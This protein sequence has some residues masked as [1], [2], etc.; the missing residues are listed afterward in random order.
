MASAA[1]PS[2]FPPYKIK[3]IG[4]FLDGG[5]TTNFPAKKAYEE[6]TGRFKK[7]KDEV[8]VLS[9][10]TGE[11]ASDLFEI[12]FGVAKSSLFWTK[13]IPNF[14]MNSQTHNADIY[15]TAELGQKKYKRF[16]LFLEHDIPL[17]ENKYMH[18]L[19]DIGTEYV[20]TKDDE[21]NKVVEI[22]LNN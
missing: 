1:A 10:G 2:Y 15:L 22:L 3:G 12:N 7:S 19:M 16:E 4:C 14:I 20:E 8:F 18:D 5:L 13:N 11:L 17:D 9:L 6:A 21:I